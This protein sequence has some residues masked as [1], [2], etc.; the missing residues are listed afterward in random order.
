MEINV[1]SI[2]ESFPRQTQSTEVEYFSYDDLMEKEENIVTSFPFA[3]ICN[4]PF[5]SLIGLVC[6]LNM[7]SQDGCG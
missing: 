1:V 5:C 2:A 4:F 7:F 3:Q 6:I